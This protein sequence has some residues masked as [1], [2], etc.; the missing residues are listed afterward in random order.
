[1]CSSS[2]NASPSRAAA[3][4][5]V[6]PAHCFFAYPITPADL[7][8]LLGLS[9]LLARRPAGQPPRPL[10][11]DE[12]LATLP[13]HPFAKKDQSAAAADGPGDAAGRRSVAGGDEPEAETA[14]AVGAAPAACAG[15]ACDDA[16]GGCSICLEGYQE[17]EMVMTLPCIHRFHSACVVPWLKQQGRTASCPMCKTPIFA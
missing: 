4:S 9:D 3:V 14:T 11:S 10:L 2:L 16:H 13:V 12:Q 7:Q 6:H 5:A 15:A 8:L 1:M 17:G